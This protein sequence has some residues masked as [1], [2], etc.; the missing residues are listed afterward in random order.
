LKIGER[1]SEENSGRSCQ[2]TRLSQS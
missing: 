2:F 1:R